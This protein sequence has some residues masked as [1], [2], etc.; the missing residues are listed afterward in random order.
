VKINCYYR[1]GT[2]NFY[3]RPMEGVEMLVDFEEMKIVAYNDRYVVA[4]PKA[5]GT[6]YRAS[7]LKP[8]SAPKLKQDDGPGFTIDGHTVR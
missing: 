8:P 1:N 2:A 3:A 6:D 7:K 5:E 4:L